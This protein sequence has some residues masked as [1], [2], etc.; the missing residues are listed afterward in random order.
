MAETLITLAIIGVVAAITMP[1]LIKSY[2]KHQTVTQLRK[3]YSD[4]SNASRR[5]ENDNGPM[6]EWELPVSAAYGDVVPYLQKYWLPYFQ[7]A[8]IASK[9]EIEKQGYSILNKHSAI[10]N[11]VI[12]NNGVILS[13]SFYVG[14]GTKYIW[15]FADINGMKGPNKVARDI[16]VFDAYS[17]DSIKFWAAD[18]RKNNIEDLINN[19]AYGCNN[20]CNTAFCKFNCGRVI[21]LSGWKI[22]DEY[23]W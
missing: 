4:L 2:Q 17:A 18:N 10:S 7:G 5:S 19:N 20:T 22:P 21:E 8:K 15:L 3:V 23:P 9:D 11:Y 1:T 13:F 12:L 16:F 14:G 6:T